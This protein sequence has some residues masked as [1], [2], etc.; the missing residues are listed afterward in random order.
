MSARF[1][2]IARNSSIIDAAALGHAVHGA[3]RPAALVPEGAVADD[4]FVAAL[5]RIELESG[6]MIQAQIVLLKG[7][8]LVPY[9]ELVTIAVD[10][11]HRQVRELWEAML[12]G[13]GVASP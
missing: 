3:I 9:R 4:P 5:R 13:V 8:D 7:P 2:I 11:R 12:A 10:E 1:P 6:R